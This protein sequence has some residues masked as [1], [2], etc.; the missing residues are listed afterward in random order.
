MQWVLVAATALCGCRSS[1][2]AVPPPARD[3]EAE[4]KEAHAKHE[5][6]LAEIRDTETECKRADATRT[7]GEAQAAAAYLQTLRVA[8]SFERSQ[9]EQ[10]LNSVI[11][12]A[13][14][15][16]PRLQRVQAAAIRTELQQPVMLTSATVFVPLQ[17]LTWIKDEGVLAGKLMGMAAIEGRGD[18]MTA[19]EAMRA[20]ECIASA[21]QARMYETGKGVVVDDQF[22]R[23]VVDAWL[24]VM[25]DAIDQ[26]AVRAVA[27]KVRALG[28]D[29]SSFELGSNAPRS[30]RAGPIKFKPVPDAVVQAAEAAL[31]QPRQQ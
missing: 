29:P 23:H 14:K 16:E 15:Q 2:E 8:E 21:Q 19:L 17:W 28:Y 5:K 25:S 3:Y 1:P 11:A 9:V 6:V 18:A 26:E 7:Q 20:Q 13:A 30:S 31:K 10:Y 24:A 12:R 4:A 27:A 22:H